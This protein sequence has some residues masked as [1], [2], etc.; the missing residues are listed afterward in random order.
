[1]KFTTYSDPGP[2]DPIYP[3]IARLNVVQKQALK[4]G[5]QDGDVFEA[6]LRDMEPKF[7]E[8]LAGCRDPDATYD[9]LRNCVKHVI[10]QLR[11]A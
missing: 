1:M 2:N 10:E 5:F 6:R 3:I 7:Q 11:A 4:S 9:A 8:F